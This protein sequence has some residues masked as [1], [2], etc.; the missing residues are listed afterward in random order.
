MHSGDG[1]KLQTGKKENHSF[2][3]EK[4]LKIPLCLDQWTQSSSAPRELHT[5]ASLILQQGLCFEIF[6][7]SWLGRS[8][9][10]EAA[11]SLGLCEG[12]VAMHG[13]R[14]TAGPPPACPQRPALLLVLDRSELAMPCTCS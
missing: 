10:G 1:D 6:P 12:R 7:P 4:F 11:S 5:T 13:C 9:M 8:P 2:S 14:G 3:L